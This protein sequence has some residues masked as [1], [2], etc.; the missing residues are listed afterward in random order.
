M[1]LY[2]LYF[3]LRTGTEK[4]VPVGILEIRLELI[5]RPP[6]PLGEDVV[7]AQI[8]LEK[9]KQAERE[10][11]FLVYAKQWWKEY[12]EIRPGHRERLVKIFAQVCASFNEVTAPGLCCIDMIIIIVLIFTEDFMPSGEDD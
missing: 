10:R 11:L 12:L 7:S 3:L 9:T 8:S 4:Q 1:H 5:P 6:D 2:H